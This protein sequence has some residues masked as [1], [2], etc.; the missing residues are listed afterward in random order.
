M[1]HSEF[2]LGPELCSLGKGLQL[3]EALTFEVSG[4]VPRLDTLLGDSWLVL[5]Q[6]VEED[7]NA[8][9][10]KIQ[11][12]VPLQCLYRTGVTNMAFLGYPEE[13][14]G[15]HNAESHGMYS[16]VNG[17]GS[18]GQALS[19]ADGRALSPYLDVLLVED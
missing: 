2:L 17:D 6:Q 10:G 3:P 9:M 18:H 1:S 15:R 16:Q 4:T 8:S 7:R 12:A 11:I 5:N 14:Q 19:A 13:M